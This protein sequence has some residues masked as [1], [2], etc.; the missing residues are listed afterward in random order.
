[1]KFKCTFCE[2]EMEKN[3]PSPVDIIV[4]PNCKAKVEIHQTNTTVPGESMLMVRVLKEGRKKKK[5]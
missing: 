4:C 5:K 3:I 2:Y 1:M